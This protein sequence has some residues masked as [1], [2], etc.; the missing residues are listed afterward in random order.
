MKGENVD[1]DSFAD[2]VRFEF[3]LPCSKNM[4]YISRLQY[5]PGFGEY[6]YYNVCC[7]GMF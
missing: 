5:E 1:G 6:K 7:L 3:I 4:Y 2:E